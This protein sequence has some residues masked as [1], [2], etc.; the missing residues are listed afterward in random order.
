MSNPVMQFQILSN[1]PDASAEFYRSLFG[2]TVNADNPLGYREIRTRLEPGNPGWHLARTVASCRLRTVVRRGRR[3]E[4]LRA[5]RRRD[6]GEACHPTYHASSRWRAGGAARSAGNLI[7]RHEEQLR[8]RMA[9]IIGRFV[10]ILALAAVFGSL[11]FASS[12]RQARKTAIPLVAE[13]Q[14]ADYQ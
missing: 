5:A 2:W 8:T 3:R 1:A 11:G 7:W 13:I 14:R 12:A 4:K 6:G 10:A 9:R